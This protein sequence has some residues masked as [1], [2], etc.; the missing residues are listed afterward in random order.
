MRKKTSTRYHQKV[1]GFLLS[2]NA[3]I[4][5]KVRRTSSKWKGTKVQTGALETRARKYTH[6][7]YRQSMGCIFY[8]TQGLLPAC[9]RV[10]HW[11]AIYVRRKVEMR[12]IL[13]QTSDPS[14]AE[15]ILRSHSTSAN[16]GLFLS[17]PRPTWKAG[18]SLYKN[19]LPSFFVVCAHLSVQRRSEE[20]T[21]S[22]I[23]TTIFMG[24][25]DILQLQRKALK[26]KPSANCACAGGTTNWW[27]GLL[28]CV[29]SWSPASS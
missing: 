4:L 8:Y 28:V 23:R 11:L 17:K 27:T 6:A 26:C 20:T 16:L 24:R 12:I 5:C 21:T 13:G 18:L 7:W 10:C 19:T 25:D 9:L 3:R 14:F 29:Y 2:K 15:Q 22:V 1:T